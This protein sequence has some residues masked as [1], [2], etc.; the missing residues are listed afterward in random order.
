VDE[1]D[2]SEKPIARLAQL[3]DAL[4]R[5]GTSDEKFS[6][7]VLGPRTSSGLM[8][9]CEE[10]AQGWQATTA[11][12]RRDEPGANGARIPVPTDRVMPWQTLRGMEIYSTWASISDALLPPRDAGSNGMRGRAWLQQKFGS[13]PGRSPAAGSAADQA[14]ERWANFHNLICTD[15]ALTAALCEELRARS[16]PRKERDLVLL[17]SEWHTE[18]GRALPVTF[19]ANYIPPKGP[20]VGADWVRT[21]HSDPGKVFRVRPADP[22]DTKFTPLLKISYASGLDGHSPSAHSEAS[23]DAQKPEKKEGPLRPVAE[24]RSAGPSQIDYLERLAQQLKSDAADSLYGYRV[25]AV[26]VLGSDIYDKILLL[27]ALRPKFP[28]AVFFTTDL[29]AGFVQPKLSEWTRNLVVAASYGLEAQ[30]R[31]ERKELGRQQKKIMDEAEGRGRRL[32]DRE[33]REIAA[34]VEYY[35]SGHSLAPFRDSHQTALH[36]ATRLAFGRRRPEAGSPNEGL[37]SHPGE[38]AF[39]KA[40]EMLDCSPRTG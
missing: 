26:G 7:V 23:A 3:M 35:Q 33:R 2:F 14:A 10:A 19:A 6:L 5:E 30:P 15:S 27:Q 37:A 1:R 39:L 34:M 4:G 24:Y 22:H 17:V 13:A 20:A 11:L 40:K 25:V 12:A 18:Y 32:E 8:Q 36:L 28:D 16:V 9:M 29:D 38:M 31:T 21:I